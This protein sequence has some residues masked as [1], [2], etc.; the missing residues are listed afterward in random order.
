MFC[1]RLIYVRSLLYRLLITLAG[2]IRPGWFIFSMLRE[3]GHAVL[4]IMF[5]GEKASLQRIQ[6]GPLRG[7]NLVLDLRNSAD[8]HM[9]LGI[10]EQSVMGAFAENL[11]GR[12]DAVVYDI[13]AGYGYHTLFLSR[14]VFPRG[15]VFAFEPDPDSLRAL[16]MALEANRV[17]NVKIIDRGVGSHG[18][19]RTFYRR[20]L[21][22]HCSL[23]PAQASG[24]GNSWRTQSTHG[25]F[26]TQVVSLDDFVFV[27]GYPVPDL[28]KIDVEGAEIEVLT[29]ASRVLAEYH[30]TIICEIHSAKLGQEVTMMLSENGYCESTFAVREDAK[31]ILA[32]HSQRH[33]GN[34][35]F[36]VG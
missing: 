30:P 15:R 14:L 5:A 7:F 19:L 28:L 1:G 34:I 2:P 29:G 16:R 36:P 3:L 35:A 4:G 25:T 22:L 23:Y 27:E 32:R 12:S 9:W 10:Y 17:Q 21:S 20:P 26:S 18:G 31:H 6:G 24:G 11:A 8:R 33:P 13:G